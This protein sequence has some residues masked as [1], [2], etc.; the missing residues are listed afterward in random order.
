M[1]EAILETEIVPICKQAGHALGSTLAIFSASELCQNVAKPAIILWFSG[2]ALNLRKD[3]QRS[4]QIILTLSLFLW[5]LIQ[6]IGF[7]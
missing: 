6:Q 2:D 4:P 3:Y 7:V 5:P 1:K